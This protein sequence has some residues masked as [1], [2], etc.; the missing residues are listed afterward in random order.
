M[1]GVA[2]EPAVAVL[3]PGPI[4][5]GLVGGAVGAVGAVGRTGSLSPGVCVGVSWGASLQAAPESN[6]ISSTGCKPLR[7]FMRGLTF[8]CTGRA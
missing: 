2:L 7:G 1:L 5:V 8:R 4:G 3:P 6:A